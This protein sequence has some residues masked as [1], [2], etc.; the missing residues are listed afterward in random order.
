MVY[1]LLSFRD[2]IAVNM[3]LGDQANFGC[4][5]KKLS[6]GGEGGESQKQATCSRLTGV[7][8]FLQRPLPKARSIPTHS[9]GCRTAPQAVV[10]PQPSDDDLHSFII[11]HFLMSGL[12]HSFFFPRFLASFS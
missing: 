6:M 8:L 1:V 11:P 7:S 4:I 5:V 10:C 2:T 12:V 9:A 3:N